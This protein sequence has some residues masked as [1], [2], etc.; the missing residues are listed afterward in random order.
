M[1]NKILVGVGI[2]LSLIS[3]VVAHEG[4]DIY[5]HHSGMG[6]MMYGAYGTGGIFFGWLVSILVVIALVL[7]IIWLVKQIQKK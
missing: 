6:A 3:F 5:G 7:L 4:E 2:I 1:K